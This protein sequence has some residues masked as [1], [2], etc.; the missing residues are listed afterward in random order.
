MKGSVI[1][2]DL[3]IAP[4]FNLNF[5]LVYFFILIFKHNPSQSY[6]FMKDDYGIDCELG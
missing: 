1:G 5:P 6:T 2:G 4:F 3:K